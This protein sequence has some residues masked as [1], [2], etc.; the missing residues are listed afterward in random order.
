STK[1]KSKNATDS[2]EAHTP[3]SRPKRRAIKTTVI[4]NSMITLESSKKGKSFSASKVVTTQIMNA[5][6]KAL[7]C[8]MGC[9]S[10]KGRIG[11]CTVSMRTS[12]KPISGL[13]RARRSDKLVRQGQIDRAEELPKISLVALR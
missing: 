3:A 9:S 4:R 10:S 13:L 5:I 2:K 12:S 7:P 6:D 11:R 1:K 8:A